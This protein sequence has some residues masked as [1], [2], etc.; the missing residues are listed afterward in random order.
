MKKTYII[1]VNPNS[2]LSPEQLF[3]EILSLNLNIT[4]KCTC[5]GVMVEGDEN[6]ISKALSYV[7]DR[8]PYDTFIKL[9]GYPINDR[10]VCRAYRGGGQSPLKSK[11]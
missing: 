10:R 6:E 2:E 7:R 4:I 3:N 9:R 11:N 1:V 5:F 8:Y